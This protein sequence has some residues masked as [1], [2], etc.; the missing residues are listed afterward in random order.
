MSEP[1]DAADAPF[2][3]RVAKLRIFA[4]DDQVA[5]PRQHQPSC[6]AFAVY[7][8][9]RWLWYVSPSLCRLQV[10]LLLAREQAGRPNFVKVSLP[11]YVIAKPSLD[12]PRAFYFNVPM[13]L[14]KRGCPVQ[15][16]A[17]RT[18]YFVACGED[19]KGGR[20]AILNGQIDEWDQQRKGLPISSKAAP[21]IGTVD[22][23][24]REYKDER[25][26]R[27]GRAKIAEKL[28]M[29]NERT[30]RPARQGR[31]PDGFKTDQVNITTRL[32]QDLQET[33]QGVEGRAVAN[34]R[35]NCDARAQG[36]ACGSS[37][38]PGRV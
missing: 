24:F 28:R 21:K 34:G 12:D 35:E 30:L 36:L 6:N 4:C 22:W 26:P 17:L 5:G 10:N 27:K 15:N 7:L 3:D 23:L 8:S 13:K 2:N 32:G 38:F 16:E 37:A 11:R 1:F 25:L 9:D 19:G 29:G 20:A 14:R 31:A 33:R 18:S